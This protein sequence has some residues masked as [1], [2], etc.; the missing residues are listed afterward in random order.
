MTL[1]ISLNYLSDSL[2]KDHEFCERT[3]NFSMVWQQM[4]E[5]EAKHFFHTFSNKTEDFNS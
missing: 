3:H 2:K 1:S 4:T 5:M